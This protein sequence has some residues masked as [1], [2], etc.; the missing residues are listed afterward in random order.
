MGYKTAQ[1]LLF[2]LETEMHK[3]RS[4]VL[5]MELHDV[6]DLLRKLEDYKKKQE[7][8]KKRNKR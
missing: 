6:L 4:L 7:Q 5:P 8:I 3:D 2:R 1:D